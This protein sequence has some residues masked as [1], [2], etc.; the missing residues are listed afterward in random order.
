MERSCQ[1]L[2]RRA[3]CTRPK[4]LKAA[5][6]AHACGE[7]IS[8]EIRKL[9]RIDRF[10]LEAVTGR[11]VL[12]W[13]ELIHMTYAETIATAYVSRSKSANWTEWAASNPRLAAV[14]ADAEKLYAT[15]NE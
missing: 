2:Q 13:R 3:G 12:Y 4:R 9:Q 10:G 1:D 15:G 5:A 8:P 6:Y 7:G 14:L 11:R